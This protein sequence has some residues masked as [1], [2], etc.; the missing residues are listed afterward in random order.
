M[1]SQEITVFLALQV[2]KVL[3]GMARWVQLDQW[4]NK[5]FLASPARQVPWAS[6]VRLA[7]VAPLTALGPCQWSSSTHP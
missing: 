1:A 7:T 4:A 6:R 3:Q 5:A 2:P